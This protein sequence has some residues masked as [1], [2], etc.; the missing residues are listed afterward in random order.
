MSSPLQR[1][2]ELTDRLDAL[3]RERDLVVSQALT[4]GATWAQIAQSLGTSPQA[5][6]KRYRWVRHDDT[7]GT[8]WHERPLST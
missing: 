6:H 4:A 2:T 7:T 3:A 5:A 8:V 1:I